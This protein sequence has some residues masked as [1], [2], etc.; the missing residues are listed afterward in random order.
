MRV[1][2]KLTS[3]PL[4]DFEVRMGK[5]EAGTRYTAPNA[6][7]PMPSS[8][9]SRVGLHVR[10]KGYR[11][12][13]EIVEVLFG[14]LPAGAAVLLDDFAVVLEPESVRGA[15]VDKDSGKP[16]EGATI[17]FERASGD[18]TTTTGPDGAFDLQVQNV[19]GTDYLSVKHDRYA[20]CYFP[21]S[22]ATPDLSIRL[23]QG[24]MLK[25][26]I[27]GNGSVVENLLPTLELHLG[28]RGPFVAGDGNANN[29]FSE[30]SKL[31]PGTY[32][33]RLVATRSG[34]DWGRMPVTIVEGTTTRYE[35]DISTF[36]GVQGML[37]SMPDPASMNVELAPAS[38]PQWPIYTMHPDA[39]GRFKIG[40]VPPG[41]YL[42]RVVDHAGRQYGSTSS[43]T[44]SPGEWVELAVQ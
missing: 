18:A 24:G 23:G 37:S 39:S 28:P 40:S 32:I 6:A 19:A 11:E 2:D 9:S 4:Q 34:E 17:G 12:A 42:I 26:V 29:G 16:I 8:T 41:R 33:L 14:N 3:K 20:P 5:D 7:F 15:V 1:M 35:V 43:C 30:W 44:I 27:H 22:D 38:M 36:G 21:L 31:A 13:N 25:G 10:A